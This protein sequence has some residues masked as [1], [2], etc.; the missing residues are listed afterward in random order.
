MARAKYKLE[1]TPCPHCD[2]E[3]SI[4]NLKQH[5][6]KCR[7]NPEW[8]PPVCTHCGRKV[9]DKYVRKLCPACYR[10]LER[11]G[12]MRPRELFDGG[13]NGPISRQERKDLRQQQSDEYENR[14]QQSM[15]NVIRA[16]E[17]VAKKAKSLEYPEGLEGIKG[18][19]TVSQWDY[20]QQNWVASFS[21]RVILLK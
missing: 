15:D 1:Y 6:A 4:N 18:W 20:K 11:T 12:Q 8:K 2:R 19:H 7:K 21:Q 3:V 5:V 17:S 10:Y 13:A 9:Y 14:I 16:A